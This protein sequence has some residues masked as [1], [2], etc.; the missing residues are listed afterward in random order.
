MIRLHSAKRTGILIASVTSGIILY[1]NLFAYHRAAN[2]EESTRIDVY[3]GF[4]IQIFAR[5][6]RVDDFIQDFRSQLFQSDFFAVLQRNDDCVY[7][8]GNASSMVEVVLAG[9]L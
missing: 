4:S 8:F 9:H 3:D 6:D 2:D 5:N 1:K 7:S